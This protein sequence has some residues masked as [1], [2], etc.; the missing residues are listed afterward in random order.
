MAR[1]LY[2]GW[3][4][5]AVSLIFAVTGKQPY[6]F[7]VFLRWVCFLSFAYSTFAF[8]K[9]NRPAW[10]WGFAI[11]AVLFN[12]LA[13]IHLKREAWQIFDWLALASV[14]VAGILFRRELKP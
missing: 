11:E 5:A 4:I 1:A 10:A 2:I 13:Q 6:T 8:A 3:S 9:M 14:I 12:P 7:Y